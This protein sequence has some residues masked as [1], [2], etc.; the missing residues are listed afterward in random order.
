[1][2]AWKEDMLYLEAHAPLQKW[3]GQKEA[4]QKSLLKH[5]QDSAGEKGATVDWDK[6]DSILKRADGIPTPILTASPDL[7]ELIKQA[8]EVQHPGH[9][10]GQLTV[11]EVTD[12]DWAILV[13]GFDSEQTAQTLAAMLN[14]QGPPIPARKVEKNGS[15]QVIAG[16]FKDPKEVEWVVHRLKIDF[17]IDAKPLPPSTLTIP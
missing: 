16:P 12:S 9:F 8:P 4:Q 2:T 6:A 1:M 11:P 17:E 3:A 5:L 14:H 15:Y 10:Y 7:S 13:A